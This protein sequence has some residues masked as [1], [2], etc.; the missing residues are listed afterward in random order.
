MRGFMV[1]LY[2]CLV[3]QSLTVAGHAA[4]PGVTRLGESQEAAGAFC[5]RCRDGD[6]LIDNGRFVAVIGASHRPDQSFYKFPTA[7]AL[8]SLVFLRAGDAS[9]PGDIMLGTPWLRVD[10]ATRHV[11]Y[12][13]VAVSRER[14]VVRVTA[15]GAW[16][17]GD[18]TDLRFEARYTIAMD[19]D[20]VDFSLTAT[21]AATQAFE[22][23]VWSA[24]FDPHQVY[25]FAPA[26]HAAHGALKFRGYP[27]AR[28]LVGWI[29]RTRR[30]AADSDFDWGWDGG[31]IVPDPLP[32]T[33]APGA[34]E[35]RTYSLVVAGEPGPVLRAVYREFRSE[36]GMD[37]VPVVFEFGSESVNSFELV[38]REAETAALFY[39]AFLDRPAPLTIELPEGRYVA[40]AR[41]FPGVARCSFEAGRQGAA[42]RLQDPPQGRAVLRVVDRDGRPV[43]GK[44][45][46][47]GIDGT[48]TPFFRPENPTRDDGYWESAKNSVFPLY[49]V[50]D[51]ELPAGTYRASASRGPEYSI[52]ARD[53]RVLAGES[54]SL[55]FTI[56]RVID[57]PDLVSMDSHLHTLESDGAVSVEDKI[58]A[59]V[60]A[61]IDLAI[62]TDHNRPVDYQ[63]VVERLGVQHE[64]MVAVGTEVT[65]PERLDYNSYPMSVQPAKHNN[66]ALD[67]L[68]T[69]RDL[70]ALF[71]ASRARDPHVILQVNHPRSW[72]FDYFNWHGLDPDSAAFATEGFDLSFDVLEVVNGAEYDRADNRAVLNDWFNLLRRGYF[73]PLV[74]TSDSHEIDQDEPGYSRTWIYHG[75]A[76]PAQVNLERLMAQI[77]AG[78]SFASNGPLLDLAVAGRYGP[79]E[80]FSSRDE[81]VRVIVDVRSAPWIETDRV[82]LY[83]NGE[84]E[85]VPL[86]VVARAPV[87]HRRGEVELRLA[88]DAFL[89]AEATG[90]T[91]LSPLVQRRVGPDGS[92]TV[93]TPYALTNPVFVD[94]DG[95]GR[96]DPPL[97]GG[98]E[99][100]ER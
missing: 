84:P 9:V 46:F 33:L 78:R 68:S 83:I 87:L 97:P 51:L 99:L 39:R 95:N 53:L 100:R 34:S 38:V 91:D 3:S 75:E 54:K 27:R 19:G 49:S 74:G 66:G 70:G 23:L 71:R 20:R 93:V 1:T 41:F 98:I 18:D 6:W 65:V 85:D 28:Q 31:M 4:A 64:L 55:A 36:S 17:R 35:T 60:A 10:H 48:P 32:V 86:S 47:H 44:V 11:L 79:G 77:R 21:N 25:D 90:T 94:R 80:M 37:S 15:R 56:D 67:P 69:D 58:R 73:R 24:F 88:T 81:R 29:D 30:V 22:N 96:Y 14:D 61:G 16:Q 57:R 8:G 50:L 5:A 63:P 45:T 82:R 92:E 52:D 59:L 7:D 76:A 26:D 12:D 89:V 42:C 2:V 43:P 40:E 72:Q 62:A 13:D